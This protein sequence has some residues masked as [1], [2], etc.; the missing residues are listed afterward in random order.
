MAFFGNLVGK[1]D[2]EENLMIN[3]GD[4]TMNKEIIDSGVIESSI[5]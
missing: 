3:D 2:F 4:R 5:H 1:I